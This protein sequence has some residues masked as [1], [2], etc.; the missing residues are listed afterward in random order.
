VPPRARVSLPSESDVGTTSGLRPVAALAGAMHARSVA[1]RRG[2]IQPFRPQSNTGIVISSRSF[3]PNEDTAPPFAAAQR[4]DRR[5]DRWSVR[6]GL[7]TGLPLFQRSSRLDLAR[8]V[9]D[10][11]RR[12]LRR[13][14]SHMR[15]LV[16]RVLYSDS[17]VGMR[18]CWAVDTK[19]WAVG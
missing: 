5:S 13:N 7:A 9:P 15:S 16:R 14:H 19:F 10:F 2:R 6:T 11:A 17:H 3:L 18:D 4:S 1:S 8:T 12:Y